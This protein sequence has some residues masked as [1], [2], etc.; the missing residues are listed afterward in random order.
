MEKWPHA[1]FMTVMGASL[2]SEP[3]TRNDC[4]ALLDRADLARVVLS[5]RCLPAALPARIAL[6]EDDHL[7]ITSRES[8]VLLAARR[9]DVISVQIDGL[10]DDGTTWSVMVSGIAT[11]VSP[12]EVQT[13]RIQDS[14]DRGAT[15]LAL[16]LS[17]V[18]GQRGH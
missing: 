14:L 13:K 6:F 10:E 17:V 4:L 5:V 3:L 8:A 11:T 2:S 16:P 9:G 18:I 1:G 12:D 15:L 7:V